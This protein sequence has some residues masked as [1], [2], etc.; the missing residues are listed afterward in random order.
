MSVADGLVERV[1]VEARQVRLGAALLAAL[2]RVLYVV[3]GAAYRAVRW[4][5]AFGGRALY[6]AG[7]VAWH[8]TRWTAMAVR[9]GWVDARDAARL[10][11]VEAAADGSGS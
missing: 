4:L 3:G 6:V 5:L 1:G 10:R 7:W 8:V 9:L 11:A 2:A